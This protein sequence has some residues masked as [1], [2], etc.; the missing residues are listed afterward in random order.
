[1]DETVGQADRRQ[2]NAVQKR[3]CINV[4]DALGNFDRSEGSAVVKAKR[5]NVGEGAWQMDGRKGSAARKRPFSNVDD[6]LGQVNGCHVITI[7]EG[8][9]L[10]MRGSRCYNNVCHCGYET[11][12]LSVYNIRDL[13]HMLIESS[14]D[15]RAII[16]FIWKSRRRV[17]WSHKHRG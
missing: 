6:A 4:G 16:V 12:M 11:V 17:S 8:V 3:S 9:G 1:M 13:S 15:I 7:L 10:N 2:T 14:T 5:A